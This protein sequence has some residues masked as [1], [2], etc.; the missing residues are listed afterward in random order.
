MA[1][2][3]G[4]MLTSAMNGTHLLRGVI[5]YVGTFGPLWMS[6]ETSMFYESR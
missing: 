4:V 6:W 3:L 2:N 1:Y 5:Y